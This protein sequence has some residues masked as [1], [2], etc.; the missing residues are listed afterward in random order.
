MSKQRTQSRP[1]EFKSKPRISRK[2]RLAAAAAV[3]ILAAGAAVVALRY[4]PD[5][6]SSSSTTTNVPSSVS[7]DDRTGTSQKPSPPDSS[8]LVPQQER[9]EVA[10]A[11]MVTVELSFGHKLP[12]IAEALREIERGY[13][14]DDGIGRTFAIL[15]AYGEPTPDGTLHMSMHISSE[16]PGIASLTF[17]RTG[18]VLWTSRIV[19]ATHPPAS[20]SAGKNL[21]ISLTDQAGNSRLLDGAG[22][23]TSIMDA[24]VKDL[25]IPVRRYW[26]DGA[27]R[28]VTFVY[29]ACGCPVK[30]MARRL[31][32]RTV[33]TRELPV[34]FPDDP[35]AV[36]AISALMGWPRLP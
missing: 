13:K 15:D 5:R 27:D 26:P 12:T 8:A 32:D 25:G 2:W 7:R 28:E 6:A 22:G 24:K 19:A 9:M 30:V 11:V 23:I 33:R 21:L 31:G 4:R 36:T 14:P 18:E 35:A 16:K 10:Q 17:R 1:R 20:A 29:S 34:I 3:I